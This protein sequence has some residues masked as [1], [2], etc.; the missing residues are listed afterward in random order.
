MSVQVIKVCIY[1]S[2]VIA[3]FSCT[4]KK[5][6]EQKQTTPTFQYERFE[7]FDNSI[8]FSIRCSNNFATE[9]LG[10]RSINEIDTN[11]IDTL[12][13]EGLELVGTVS[14]NDI[15]VCAPTDTWKLIEGILIVEDSTSSILI[16]EQLFHKRFLSFHLK[17]AV[18]QNKLNQNELICLSELKSPNFIKMN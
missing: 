9:N 3:L 12:M 4:K 1:F 11:S 2:C 16:E 17:D 7:V 15:G 8:G 18:F 13:L 6:C 14:K 5:E 10:L